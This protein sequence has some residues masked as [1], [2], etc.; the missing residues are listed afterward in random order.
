MTSERCQAAVFQ[1]SNRCLLITES[2]DDLEI[3]DSSPSVAIDFRKLEYR[4]VSTTLLFPGFSSQLEFSYTV[5]RCETMDHNFH[6]LSIIY[7]MMHQQSVIVC[8]LDSL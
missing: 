4:K 2:I 8:K 5:S 6:E 7:R 1:N 3:T